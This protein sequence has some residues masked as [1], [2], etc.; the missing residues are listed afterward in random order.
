MAMA[1]DAT[2]LDIATSKA[3]H[4]LVNSIMMVNVAKTNMGEHIPVPA[5]PGI[6]PP[7]QVSIHPKSGQT[8]IMLSKVS[9]KDHPHR[10]KIVELVKEL[11]AGKPRHLRQGKNAHDYLMQAKTVFESASSALADSTGP[12]R[13]QA[14]KDVV[15]NTNKVSFTQMVKEGKQHGTA[16]FLPKLGPTNIPVAPCPKED[17]Q[18]VQ[19]K[20]ATQ[21]GTKTNMVSAVV[22]IMHQIP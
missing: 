6:Q 18:T 14:S 20:K 13:P 15:G 1:N 19:H 9:I 12:S 7:Q 2:S 10:E 21:Q 11:H 16:I 4:S 8:M 22:P 3:I 17:W 5:L